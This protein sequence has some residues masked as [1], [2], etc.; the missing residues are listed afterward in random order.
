MAKGT[1]RVR[2][3]GD[4]KDLKKSLRGAGSSIGLFAKG[5]LAAGTALAGLATAGAV[6][7]VKTAADLEQAGIAF[8]T[9]LG[10][11]KKAQ[12]FLKGLTAFAEK[13]PFELPGLIAAS[14]QLIGVGASAKT[15]IPTLTAW[16]DAAGAL[17][18]K[19]EAFERVMIAVTQ[20]MSKGKV[21][22]EELMQI[23]EAGIPIYPLL[24]KAMGKTVPEIQKLGSEGKL[25]AED[26]FPA[27]EKQMGKDYGGTMAKQSKTLTGLWS[28][29]MDTI[30]IGLATAVGPM[31][32]TFKGAL[33]GAIGVASAAFEKLPGAVEAAMGVLSDIGSRIAG[34]LGEADISSAAR[35][36]I[37]KIKAWGQDIIDGIVVGVKT[38]DFGPLGAALG[39]ALS[40]V[41]TSGLDLGIRIIELIASIDWFNVGKAAA[42]FAIEFVVGLA[43]GI[44]K[45]GLPILF[46]MLKDH[47]F[48]I[49]IASISVALLPAKVIGA[50]GQLLGKIPFVGPF[51]KWIFEGFANLSKKIW[52]PIGRFFRDFFAAM[53]RGLGLGGTFLA[54]FVNWLKLLPTRIERAAIWVRDKAVDLM[55]RFRDALIRGG[56]RV[57][58]LMGRAFS[59]ITRPFRGA[60]NWLWNTG[61]NII[62]GL[63]S[64]I[65]NMARAAADAAIG[66]VRDAWNAAK[67][68]LGIGS[69]SKLFTDMGMDSMR[70]LQIGLDSITPKVDLSALMDMA[71]LD[72]RASLAVLTEGAGRGA[73]PSVPAPTGGALRVE[74]AP[75]PGTDER[76]MREII[77]GLRVN[78]RTSGRGSAERFFAP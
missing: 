36:L 64:G 70:G 22:A 34:A 35:G 73:A 13:T 65:K 58:Q 39:G 17:G 5:A 59:W 15:V 37:G 67:N 43:T 11:G 7:G 68:F 74:L 48:D 16:G 72:A 56:E 2:I 4:D 30:N 47:W 71:E 75:A 25:L 24:A 12:K 50:I 69:P 6:L 45:D 27:L 19:Q 3:V 63:I 46:N 44:I 40:G 54:R 78:V 10:S 33:A 20:S 55:R 28:T 52:G 76:L 1:L 62:R 23:T 29:F 9:L 32:D 53:G 41:L 26:I 8:E 57:G 18:L 38:G 49:L 14:R 61:A 51:L 60:A 77:K 66:V 31:M 42:K 21:Q